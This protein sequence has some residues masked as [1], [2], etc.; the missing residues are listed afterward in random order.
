MLK[1]LRRFLK[2]EEDQ[3]L[4]LREKFSHFRRLLEA[5]NQAL[6]I[7]ADMEEKLA[8]EYLFDT[9]Y[10]NSQVERL[11]HQVT[12]IITELNKLTQDRYPELLLVHRQLQEAIQLELTAAPEIPETPYVLSLAD[13][14]Q[15]MAASVGSKMA[16]LG[17]IR[18]LLGMRVPEG[19][20]ISAWA[21]KRFLETSGLAEELE[22]YLAK[23]SLDDLDSLEA[24]SEQMQARVRQAQLPA[25]LAAALIEAGQSLAGKKVSVRSSA[26][27]EDTHYSFAG[28]F[29]TL[30]NAS[31]DRLV[32]HYKEIVA[33]KF[34]SRGIFYWKYQQFSVNELPMAVGCLAMVA[35]K[36][37]GVMFSTDPLAPASDSIVITAVWGLGKYAVD[38]RISPDI[39]RVSRGAGHRLQEQRVPPK[40]VALVC[41]PDSGVMEIS[42]DPG[43]GQSACL[44]PEQLERLAE[45]ALRL[46]KHFGGPQD[47]EWAI[48]EHDNIFVLQ[49]RPLRISV[50]AFGAVTAPPPEPSAPPLLKHGIRAVGG[51]AAGPV[52]LFFSDKDTAN[53]PPGAVVVAR[54]PSARL[55]LVMDR[56]AAI[57]TEV[58]SPTDHMSILAR[59]FKVPTLV[60]VGG[61]TR[62]LRTGQ[63]VTVDADAARV[64]QGIIP[65][66]LVSPPAEEAWRQN[67]VFDKLRQILR[68]ITPLSLLDP[69]SPDFQPSNCRTWHD[70]TRFSHEKAMDAMFDQDVEESLRASGIVRLKT[71]IP[72]N[73]FVLDLGGGLKKRDSREVIEEQDIVC[74]PFKA[75]LR[76]FHHPRVSWAGQVVVD[77]KG[78]M[79]VF[80][81]T[82]Y[83][84]AKSERGLGGKSFAIITENYLNFNSRLGYHFSIVDTFLSEEQNDNYIS[85]QFKGGAAEPERRE[86]RAR[87]LGKILQELGYKVQ[88]K[89]DLVQGRLVKFSLLE[90]EQTLEL[91][92]L[93]MAFARQLDLALGS[94]AIMN[95]F[96]LAFREGDYSLRFLRPGEASH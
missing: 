55:V 17:E 57:I 10:I 19:F 49:T 93:L 51:A 75:L 76:G 84:M 89:G 64:Y 94:E 29:R 40:P 60:E 22:E 23:A 28:Q 37:S 18:N 90:T 3:Q 35:A 43:R 15:E 36:A 13:L 62:V 59:E 96:L 38:G 31:P 24:I 34:T 27:G 12:D 30:L 69:D 50:T 66:L 86:R 20:A 14:T 85:F 16:N 77:L 65:E 82:L 92:G 25:D 72:L 11:A 91:T 54:Q 53:I 47:I 39:Y 68:K 9:G 74:R 81:N 61:A 63:M 45:I 5:N 7:M 4:R 46:E 48:D 33:G 88:I 80:A 95:R 1:F 70:I 67:P 73:L 71:E 83:D 58:G 42:L 56:I 2:S 21:Y 32:D 6:E 79:S 8:E 44:A 87:L 26:V 41:A 52:Y 78:F